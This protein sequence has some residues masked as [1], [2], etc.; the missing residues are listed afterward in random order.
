MRKILIL[1]LLLLLPSVMVDATKIQ[2]KEAPFHKGEDVVVCGVL[3]ETHAC[4]RVLYL[5][6]DALP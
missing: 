2:P 1:I 3:K 5:N 4:S 6:F